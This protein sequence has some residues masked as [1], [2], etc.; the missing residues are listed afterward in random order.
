MSKILVPPGPQVSGIAWLLPLTP[1]YRLRKFVVPVT[2]T[3]VP[4]AIAM[5]AGL[6]TVGAGGVRSRPL[7]YRCRTTVGVSTGCP[8]R[9]L[10]RGG[11]IAPWPRLRAA[12]DV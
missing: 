8:W 1:M 3:L 11:H 10:R 4:S 9:F 5:S 12:V 2:R 6:V 7:A